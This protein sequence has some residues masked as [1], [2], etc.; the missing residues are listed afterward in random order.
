MPGLLR[1]LLSLKVNRDKVSMLL[2]GSE[3][4]VTYKPSYSEVL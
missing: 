2:C 1:I 4:K 3:P